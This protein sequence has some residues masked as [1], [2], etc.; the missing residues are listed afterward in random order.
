MSRIP[1]R[2]R[3]LDALRGK[4]ATIFSCIGT[5]LTFTVAKGWVDP[6]TAFLLSGV[7]SA[8]GFTI[9]IADKIWQDGKNRPS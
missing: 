1:I 2:Y 7:A 5:V 9:N 8:F 6:A 3:V 4:K